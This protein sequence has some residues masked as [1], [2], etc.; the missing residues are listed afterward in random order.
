[1]SGYGFRS[2]TQTACAQ[3][4]N[5]MPP[6][7]DQRTPVPLR[8][9]LCEPAFKTYEESRIPSRFEESTAGAAP[10]RIRWLGITTCNRFPQMRRCIMSYAADLR[11][12]DRKFDMVVVDDSADVAAREACREWLGA[13]AKK[14]QVAVSYAG[15]EEKREFIDR[16]ARIGISPQLI[17]FALTNS[18]GI[19]AS[20]GA[21]R[22]TLLLHTL[23]DLVLSCD[24]DSVCRLGDLRHGDQSVRVTPFGNANMDVHFVTSRRVA[25]SGVPQA[26]RDLMTAHEELLGRTLDE[27]IP[28]NSQGAPVSLRRAGAGPAAPGD[29]RVGIT[30][31]GV[32]GDSGLPNLMS[33]VFSRGQVRKR[34]LQHWD[35]ILTPNSLNIICGVPFPVI[36]RKSS[37][38]MTSAT[39]LDNRLL[40]PP[41]LPSGRGEDS[42]FG[43]TTRKCFPDLYTGFIPVA[44]L[45]A[46]ET[47][48]ACEPVCA[49][50]RL[51]EFLMFILEACPD[52]DDRTVQERLRRVGA[53]LVECG[54]ACPADFRDYLKS[55]AIRRI[56]A[57]TGMCEYL[58]R[59]FHSEPECWALEIRQALARLQQ[60]L[61]EA[62]LGLPADLPGGKCDSRYTALQQFIRNLGELSRAWPDIVA[63]SLLLRRSGY[64]IGHEL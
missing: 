29:G 11:R 36:S 27:V 49:P 35:L 46:R 51:S 25:V 22:N 14:F 60:Q 64:C 9:V 43:P 45:H 48:S 12:H 15:Y 28:H 53:H 37:I 40:L 44:V 57:L 30:I 63:A 42:L 31:S 7:Q 26:D 10:D 52:Q 54:A 6:L 13:F 3:A 23:G 1:V 4:P 41:F 5:P 16:L 19:G 2:V 62:D 8:S 59:E 55:I 58:L 33:F 24:D 61:S 18:L 50:P 38:M 20:P 32:L 39:G 21:N 34:L 56:G 47:S 17:R